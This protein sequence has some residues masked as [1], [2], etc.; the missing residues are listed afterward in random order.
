[1]EPT[2]SKIDK[3]RLM[4]EITFIA[5][6]ALEMGGE[7]DSSLFEMVAKEYFKRT[8]KQ[9]ILEESEK[10]ILIQRVNAIKDKQENLDIIIKSLLKGWKMERLPAVDLSIIRM[11]VYDLLYNSNVPHNVTVSEAVLLADCFSD[12]KNKKF[13][14]GI[15]SSVLSGLTDND[16]DAEKFVAS[17][18]G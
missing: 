7:A 14:N 2:E 8:Q 12:E 9:L 15:L 18:K 4:R 16:N 1:M 5:L 13:I 17:V 11:S 10:D 3:K 6:Y